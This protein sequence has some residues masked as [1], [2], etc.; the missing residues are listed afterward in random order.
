MKTKRK[1][2]DPLDNAGKIFPATSGKLD[3]KVFRFVCQLKEPVDGRILQEALDKTIKEFP[4][5]LSVIKK[6]LFWNYLESSDKVPVVGEEAIQPLSPIYDPNKKG[7]LFR[8]HYYRE[9]INLEVYHSL[10]DGTGA[11]QFLKTLVCRYLQLAHKEL[12]GI[13][14][15]LE[16]RASYQAQMDD[17]FDRYYDDTL[18]N[19]IRKEER[20]RHAY[21]FHGT[22]LSEYRIRVI[23]GVMS[24]AELKKLAKE[25]HTTFTVLIAAL[26]LQAIGEE[27]TLR[28]KRRP[29]GIVIPVNLRSFFKS[30]SARNFFGS[31]DVFYDFCERSGEFDDMIDC[32]RHAFETE[33][34]KERLGE[35]VYRLGNL[36]KNPFI[37]VVPLAIKQPFMKYGY[38]RVQK[39]Y[40][41]SLSNIGR[42]QMPEKLV[43]YID[44]FDVFVSTKRKQACM[45]SFGD[46]LVISFTSPYHNTELEKNFFRSL[47]SRGVKVEIMTNYD[48]DEEFNH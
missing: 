12:Q 23:S 43:P 42:I 29:V 31:I 26:I 32:I 27:M 18:K 11:E 24:A 6:G 17:S 44:L 39:Q 9:R 33:L 25:Y 20:Q 40:T 4:L 47:T 37:R 46:C 1:R 13:N 28:E 8:V 22:K 36:E 14:I 2:W 38:E 19:R 5:F 10:T 34:T 45:C 21:Q 35:K 48:G 41:F 3:T 7:L 15:P 30:D 16:Y